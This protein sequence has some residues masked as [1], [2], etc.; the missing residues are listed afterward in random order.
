MQKITVCGI[1]YKIESNERK[2]FLAKRANTKKFLPGKFE[3]IGGHV[4]LEDKTLEEA[5][6]REVMEELGAEIIVEKIAGEFL[7]FNETQNSQSIEVIYWIQF[8]DESQIKINPEDH[9]EFI[10]VNELEMDSLIEDKCDLEYL[11]IKKI[12]SD[13]KNNL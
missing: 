8:L 6:K 5:L 7:Y 3:L 10:W 2:I 11:A 4:E 13:L 12:F 1:A 9:S